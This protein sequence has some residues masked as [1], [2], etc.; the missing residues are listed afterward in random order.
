MV[1]TTIY[2]A[3]RGRLHF[4]RHKSREIPDA[5]LII[6]PIFAVP[7]LIAARGISPLRPP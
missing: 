5:P 2:I 6:T 1:V 4:F 7:L 3:A